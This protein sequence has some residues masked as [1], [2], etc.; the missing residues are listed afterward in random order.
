MCSAASRSCDRSARCSGSA[1][2]AS[3]PPRC[4]ARAWRRW[5][6]EPPPPPPPPPAPALRRRAP[7]PPTM[8]WSSSAA[9]PPPTPPPPPPPPPP[10]RLR[11]GRL[12][13]FGRLQLFSRLRRRSGGGHLPRRFCLLGKLAVALRLPLR[14]PLFASEDARASLFLARLLCLLL[15]D[16]HLDGGASLFEEAK[17][18]VRGSRLLRLFRRTC[19]RLVQAVLT[20]HRL[21]LTPGGEGTAAL[22]EFGH[23]PLQLEARRC[24]AP[25][26]VG[27]GL[28]REHLLLRGARAAAS[29]SS[30]RRCSAASASAPP[31]PPPTPPPPR[32]HLPC[33]ADRLRLGFLEASGG[34]DALTGDK[35]ANLLERWHH[36]GASAFLKPDEPQW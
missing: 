7:A 6:T 18:H 16:L 11:L 36:L 5:R 22:L 25:H 34:A 27:G 26:L 32:Q 29:S 8:E 20:A 9:P 35:A 28:P 10:L 12:R 3:L 14:P 1:K 15:G 30:C 2:K 33:D 17:A 23:E 19:R 21:A 31:P 4:R 13:C 24:E